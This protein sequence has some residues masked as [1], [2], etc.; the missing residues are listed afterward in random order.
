MRGGTGGVRRLQG[1]VVDDAI[2]APEPERHSLV[3]TITSA[4]RARLTSRRRGISED[5]LEDIL[6]LLSLR[7]AAQ[8]R[9][10]R[11]PGQELAKDAS[12]SV[13]SS[14]S[15]LQ[16]RQKLGAKKKFLRGQG[17]EQQV[18]GGVSLAHGVPGSSGPIIATPV[19]GGLHH[20]YQRVA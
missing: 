15:L 7:H 1:P 4:L 10:R 2:A 5:L 14:P 17:I 18:P 12:W 16:E 3:V 8:C 9:Q 13:Y 11:S 6:G 20:A 19:L